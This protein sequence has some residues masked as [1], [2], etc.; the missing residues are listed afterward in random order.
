M[1][2]TESADTSLALGS[3]PSPENRIAL[4]PAAGPTPAPTAIERG[5][6]PSDAERAGVAAYF[7]AVDQIEPGKMSGN[8]EDVAGE[9]AAAL[10]KGDTSGL[11]GMIQ[12]TEAARE[13]LAALTP[14][15]ACAGHHQESLASLGDA[16][17]VLRSLKSA[18]ESPDPA[19]GLSGVAARAAALRS[20][21]EALQKEESALRQRYGLTR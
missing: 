15:A 21:S 11:D 19:A 1:G 20:R 6:A 12:E 13:R 14:P 3:A 10:A 9:M 18:M 4:Q 5:S 16:L 8:A 7:E 2:T 17:E